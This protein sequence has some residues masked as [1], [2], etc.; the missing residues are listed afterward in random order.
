VMIFFR[1][2]FFSAAPASEEP[3]CE[4]YSKRELELALRV[5]SVRPPDEV[6]RPLKILIE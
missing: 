3:I 1:K 4:R 5:L 2:T 6:M